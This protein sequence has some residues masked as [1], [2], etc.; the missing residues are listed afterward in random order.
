MDEKISLKRKKKNDFFSLIEEINSLLPQA[1]TC[2]GL[3]GL[4]DNDF[5][6]LYGNDHKSLEV[7]N[8]LEIGSCTKVKLELPT[9]DSITK[10]QQQ[11]L[12]D[13]IELME[14]ANAHKG[15]KIV[16]CVAKGLYT[17]LQK[18][19][20]ENEN[21]YFLLQDCDF[22]KIQPLLANG[23]RSV[24]E[25]KNQ[26]SYSLLDCQHI[27]VD[28]T[29]WPSAVYAV[30]AYFEIYKRYGHYPDIWL[31][32]PGRKENV[33]FI[34]MAVTLGVQTTAIKEAKTGYKDF[35]SSKNLGNRTLVLLPLHYSIVLKKK[36]LRVNWSL[37]GTTVFLYMDDQVDELIRNEAFPLYQTLCQMS[38]NAEM[39]FSLINS[40][41]IMNL[42]KDRGAICT[43]ADYS[44]RYY[45][46]IEE[47]EP[48]L[49]ELNKKIL[50]LVQNFSA[51]ELNEEK[52]QKL[53]EQVICKHKEI[54][55]QEFK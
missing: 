16:V 53:Y 33:N 24:P 50:I 20:A 18:K 52:Q 49:K 25:K 9:D 40:S 11:E 2:Y 35:Y 21:I 42:L 8:C 38:E 51:S 46:P 39:I 28:G 5:T 32:S 55:Y 34:S 29:Y 27:Y 31:D 13:L 43:K 1:D 4:K 15:K 44:N 19:F 14:S 17:K 7:C 48:K 36:L 37:F 3:E 23:T 6:F 22:G 10:Q 30:Y 26:C 54:L 47:I 12:E 41:K 45:G